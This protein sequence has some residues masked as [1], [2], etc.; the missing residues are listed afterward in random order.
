LFMFLAG[1]A[2]LSPPLQRPVPCQEQDVFGDALDTFQKTASTVALEKFKAAYPDSLWA[3]RADGLIGS[4]KKLAQYRKKLETLQKSGVAQKDQIDQLKK[5]N[6]Q[7][8]QQLQQLKRLLI[9]LEKH[10]Q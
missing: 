6:Q 1:C 5:T 4:A 3:D 8:T 9:E 10:P 7:L 2:V